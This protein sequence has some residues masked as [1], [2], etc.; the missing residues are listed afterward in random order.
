MAVP[1][2]TFHL[3]GTPVRVLTNAGM[4]VH[5]PAWAD[6]NTSLGPFNEEDPETDVVR[7][8]HV[9]LVPGYYAALFMHRRGITPKTAFQELYGAIQARGEEVTCQDVITWLKVA[10]TAR[11]GGGANSALPIVHHALHPVHLPEQVYQYL[12]GKVRGDLPALAG[13]DPATAEVTSTLA[14]A[15]RALASERGGTDGA[16]GDRPREPKSVQEVYKETFG[17]LLRF[18]NV[19]QPNEV[20]PLWGRLANCAK[21]EHQTIISQE[22]QR[23]CMARGLSTAL[24]TPVVNATLKQMVTGFQFMGHGVDDLSTGC[25]PFLVSYSGTASNVQALVVA[26]LGDLLAQGEQSATLTDIRTLREREKVKF[27]RDVTEVCIT[28]G[29]YAV[30]CQTLFQGVGPPNPI[31]E[32]LWTLYAGMQNAGPFVTE[33][34]WQVI[35]DAPHVT[36][37]YFACTVRS[38]QVEMYEYLQSV[39]TNVAASHEGVALPDFRSFLANLKKGSFHCSSDWVKIPEEYMDQARASA[40]PGTGNTTRAPG[41]APTVASSM[42]STRTGVSSLTTDTRTG[43][44]ASQTLHPTRSLATSPSV[45]VALARYYVSI[46]HPPMM[47]A[48]SFVWHVG[49]EVDV[50]RT[51]GD[52]VHTGG[53]P[54]RANACAC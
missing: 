2:T 25:Q 23:V 24:Y 20:A 34:F 5:L 9:Q 48:P 54:L 38:I 41:T 19:T 21:G 39:A 6:P 13:P 1:S 17:T 40:N 53:S 10:C 27:P 7:P 28:L 46:D 12:I 29:R 14:G 3:A 8:R 42:A 45:P 36:N 15:L 49:S 11:G 47:Q 16:V 44:P 50:S 26:R 22:L 4:I 33:K 31:V 37:V 30:L 51:A 43:P 35:A 32:T 52:A 18:C